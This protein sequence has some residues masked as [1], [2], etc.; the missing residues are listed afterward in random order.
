MRQIS[1][2]CNAVSTGCTRTQMNDFPAPPNEDELQRMSVSATLET[3]TGGEGF[4]RSFDDLD[5]IDDH[6]MSVLAD[7][8]PIE[9]AVVLRG[10]N[11]SQSGNGRNSFNS[12]DS[13]RM[14]DT[15]AETSN[16]SVTSSTNTSAAGHNRLHSNMSNCSGDSGAQLSLN[17]NDSKGVGLEVLKEQDSPD[18]PS[19]F[20][21]EIYG[22]SVSI[23][24]AKTMNNNPGQA[25]VPGTPSSI[26]PRFATVRKSYTLPH[27][28]NN[29]T[30]SSVVSTPT[31]LSPR[32]RK[33]LSNF[34][35]LTDEGPGSPTKAVTQ[36]VAM[37]NLPQE[38]C[39]EKIEKYLGINQ[40]QQQQPRRP[41]PKSLHGISL[42]RSLSVEQD[43]RPKAV[44]SPQAPLSKTLARLQKIKESAAS[45]KSA[46][47]TPEAFQLNTPADTN[48]SPR[49]KHLARFLGYANGHSSTPKAEKPPALLQAQSNLSKSMDFVQSKTPTDQDLE[50][51]IERN[52]QSNEGLASGSPG[53][54]GGLP[55]PME[56][57][58]PAIKKILPSNGLLLRVSNQHRSSSDERHHSASNSPFHVS[59]LGRGKG[60][61]NLQQHQHYHTSSLQRG[62]LGTITKSRIYQPPNQPPPPKRMMP[63]SA[64]LDD[65]E[66]P[67]NNSYYEPVMWVQRPAVAAGVGGRGGCHPCCCSQ[68]Q[69]RFPQSCHAGSASLNGSLPRYPPVHQNQEIYDYRRSQ[70]AAPM[71]REFRSNSVASNYPINDHNTTANYN[72]SDQHVYLSMTRT[73]RV[74]VIPINNG[75]NSLD[76]N[77]SNN[78]VVQI[79]CRESLGESATSE[80]ASIFNGGV[81][82]NSKVVSMGNKTCISVNE[83][84]LVSTKAI[85]HNSQQT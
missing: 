40:Q 10:E 5:D 48:T 21:Q 11:L 55:T 29:Q 63:R 25:I 73:K 77:N 66:P 81:D 20:D 50:P 19:P 44:Q 7:S 24:N 85:V 34:L 1:Y 18:F 39:N 49:K 23:G 78:H 8:N 84:S 28:I 42:E 13:G 53:T 75:P 30:S 35:G 33:D 76:P 82:P 17:S 69:Y 79:P 2:E 64:T 26:E 12:S 41:R 74:V 3:V 80:Y 72:N 4:Y 70:P 61:N 57:M 52:W 60:G 62:G 65:L 16:S 68:Q 32:K 51:E 43:R 6:L 47:T 27:G 38:N 31:V 22:Q 54:P 56:P 46:P 14:S 83:S 59:S 71:M 45:I 67:P 9:A 58:S 37:Q 36:A 15:Y